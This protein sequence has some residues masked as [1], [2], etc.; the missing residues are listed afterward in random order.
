MIMMSMSVRVMAVV[1]MPMRVA[2]IV[3]MVVVIMIVFVEF[4]SQVIV[5]VSRVQNLHLNKIEYET[6]NSNYQHDVSF[7]FFSDEK[8]LC[9]LN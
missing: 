8:A 6:Q 1:V 5:T 2:M 9:S 4:T 7:N 3:S